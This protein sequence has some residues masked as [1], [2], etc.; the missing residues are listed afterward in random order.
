MQSKE[1][2]IEGNIGISSFLFL[3]KEKESAKGG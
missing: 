2:K 3:L 1:R